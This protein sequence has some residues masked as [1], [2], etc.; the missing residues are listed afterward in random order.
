MYIF[1]TGV[2]L[3][4]S[5]CDNCSFLSGVHLVLTAIVC[6]LLWKP[7]MP[8]GHLLFTLLRKPHTPISHF[9]LVPF[10]LPGSSILLFHNCFCQL[11]VMPCWEVLSHSMLGTRAIGLW[12]LNKE[13][14]MFV[15]WTLGSCFLWE[16]W[17]GPEGKGTCHQALTACAWPP[18]ST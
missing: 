15:T 8:V 9:H 3:S 12:A 6:I 7:Y 2:P 1:K 18:K 10:S 11:T 14:K 16:Q 13:P 17:E 4:L 5:L